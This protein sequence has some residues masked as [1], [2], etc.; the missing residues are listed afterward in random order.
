LKFD[1]FGSHILT[2]HIKT[3]EGCADSF[4]MKLEVL[5]TPSADFEVVDVCNGDTSIF[6][7]LYSYIGSDS[8][9]NTWIFGTKKGDTSSQL[10]PKHLFKIPQDELEVFAVKYIRKSSNGCTDSIIKTHYVH[11]LPDASF[12]ASAENDS[13]VLYI[14]PQ[15][16]NHPDYRY[17]WYFGNGD[18]STAI[19]P[20][21]TYPK[22]FRGL[23]TVCLQIEFDF[24]P[25]CKSEHCLDI[26]VGP[27]L[28]IEQKAIGNGINITPNPSTDFFILTE[29]NK[30][31]IGLEFLTLY[32]QT[33]ALIK[34]YDTRK[35]EHSTT[36]VSPGI[37]LLKVKSKKGISILRFVVSQD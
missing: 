37:Y 36:G 11:G 22:S 10:N 5:E 18:S 34:N 1:S 28:S 4:T 13:G 23:V 26:P 14:H 19:T 21:Y 6:R 32:D 29:N 2:H 33:G 35:S 12:D 7:N 9:T 15:K 20:K 27:Q 17:K 16:I 3:G 8:V 24:A 30:P 25:Y 31:V